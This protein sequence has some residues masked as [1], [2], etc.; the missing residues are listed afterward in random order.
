MVQL[1][2]ILRFVDWCDGIYVI[3]DVVYDDFCEIC[4][5]FGDVVVC[6]IVFVCKV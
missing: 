5:L 3:F 6:L 1:V 2:D 4:E